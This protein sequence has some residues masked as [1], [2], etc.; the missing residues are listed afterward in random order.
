[1]YKKILG[2]LSLFFIGVLFI[3]ISVFPEPILTRYNSSIQI[4]L[5]LVFL[6]LW[7]RKGNSIFKLNSLPLW[8]YII[9]I[10]LSSFFAIN[11]EASFMIYLNITLPLVFIYYVIS[12]EFEHKLFFMNLARIICISSII[13]SILGAIETIFRFGPV[14]RYFIPNIYCQ[15]LAGSFL[16]PVSTQMHP[17]VLAS[18]L[19]YSLPFNFFLFK[20]GNPVFRVWGRIGMILN[21]LV[22]IMTFSRAALLGVIA[23]TLV[24]LFIQK[25]YSL[26]R[27][28]LA[29]LLIFSF[30]SSVLPSPFN[31]L[32]IENMIIDKW[33]SIFSIV[34]LTRFII[35]LDIIGRHPFVGLGF[36]N[37]RIILDN[38]YFTI[39]ATTGI[40]GFL[41]F[42]IF[43]LY[44]IRIARKKIYALDQNSSERMFLLAVFMSFIG[45]LIDVMGYDFI[46]WPNPYLYFC[47][48][49]GCIAA[50]SKEQAVN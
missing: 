10:S 42:M 13:V 20:Q 38:T 47:I 21:M 2:N 11:K 39:P 44:L 14:Y 3:F 1:M 35:A 17:K 50:F 28:L 18:Y 16:K 40:I 24:Y 7:A 34:S 41:G 29:I 30:A 5:F 37:E 22:I 8:I 19:V 46:Y 32:S 36:K 27:F 31:V 45:L 49:V 12:E 15:K 25:N 43:I 23:S 9:S 48:L 26:I 33:T 4:F 6:D